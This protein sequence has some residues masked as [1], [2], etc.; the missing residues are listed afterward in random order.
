MWEYWSGKVE[1]SPRK[2]CVFA[3]LAASIATKSA[4][5]LNAVLCLPLSACFTLHALVSL[6]GCRLP[7]GSCTAHVTPPSPAWPA[8]GFDEWC[9]YCDYAAMA[10]RALERN[11]HT[12]SI[13]L[14]LMLTCA[15]RC[16]SPT[17]TTVVAGL[18][19]DETG[20]STR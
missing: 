13:L 17:D 10:T 15:Y 14:T 7:I 1:S 16:G 12:V 5:Q 8:D 4:P 20:N 9:D 19:M 3:K 18:I 11:G 6:D 2:S